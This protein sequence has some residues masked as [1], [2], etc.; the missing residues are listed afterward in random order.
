MLSVSPLAAAWMA[1]EISA[2]PARLGTFV[3]VT[4]P[5]ASMP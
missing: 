5:K 3:F 2:E 1:S 4:E